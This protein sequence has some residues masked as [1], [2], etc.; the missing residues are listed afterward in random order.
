MWENRHHYTGIS[1]LPYDN[2]TY[3]QAPFEDCAKEAYDEMITHLHAI[4][5][6]QVHELDDNTNL[7]D[8]QACAGGACEINI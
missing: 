1:V 6:T 3:V 5:L 2:G 8:Q 7:T 4:D